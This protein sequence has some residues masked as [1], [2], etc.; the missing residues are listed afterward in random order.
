MKSAI[1]DPE[2]HK[3]VEAIITSESYRLAI[4]DPKFLDRDDVRGPRLEVDYLKPELLLRQR[5]IDGT[6]VVF[7]STRICEPEAAKRKLEALRAAVGHREAGSLVSL[8]VAERL[9]EKARFYEIARDLAREVGRS[10]RA[11]PQQSVVIMTGSGPGIMEAAN[12][13]AFDVG[14]PSVGLNISLPH[15]Q[16]PNP[17]VSPDLCFCVHYFGIRKLHFLKRAKA[18]VVFPGGFG[19]IDELFETL[20]LIQTRKIK[21]IPVVLVGEQFW[22]RAIDIDFLVEEGV[23]DPEDRDLFWYAETGQEIWDDILKWHAATGAPLFPPISNNL[24]R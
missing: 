2:A 12:R 20:T 21:P 1:D 19:T 22:R 4:E 9:L 24:S 10:N 8:Q 7:G 3:R 17:Y 5:G 18:L 11:H 15:E 23:V 16:F 14:A 6:I 13:G